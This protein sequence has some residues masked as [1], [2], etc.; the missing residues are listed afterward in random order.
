MKGRKGREQHRSK[1]RE[2]EQGRENWGKEWKVRDRREGGS[3]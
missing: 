3:G 1:G 2:R